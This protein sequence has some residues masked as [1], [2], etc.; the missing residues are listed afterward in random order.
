MI[1]GLAILLSL[2]TIGILA[3]ALAPK[4]PHRSNGIRLECEISR[5]RR[6]GQNGWQ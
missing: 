4:Y 2:I 1:I 3:Y 5:P 6:F